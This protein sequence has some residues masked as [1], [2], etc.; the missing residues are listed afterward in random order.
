MLASWRC[1]Q[2]TDDPKVLEAVQEIWHGFYVNELEAFYLANRSVALVEHGLQA[3]R[4]TT[5][6]DAVAAS[7]LAFWH[8]GRL[9]ILIW[10]LEE[11]ATKA[12]AESRETF[13]LR[14]EAML[15]AMSGL[16]RNNPGAFRPILDIQHVELFLVWRAL[17]AF[18]QF[19]NIDTWLGLLG[20]RLMM[21]RLGKTG[22]PFISGANSWEQA[23][24]RAD[25]N[26]ERAFGDT[27]SN[28]L[29]M[30][31]ELSCCLSAARRDPLLR[32]YFCRII[33]AA[34]DEGKQLGKFP[35]ISLMSWAPP[36]GWEARIL[37]GAVVDGIAIPTDFT[38]DFE[39]EGLKLAEQLAS[40]AY[41]ARQSFPLNL[42]SR[43]PCSVFASPIPPEFWRSLILKSE[44]SPTAGAE[45]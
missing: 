1:A 10:A 32:F 20:E 43:V 44:P 37:E 29:L 2:K 41:A 14:R 23:F 22:P 3:E 34:D 25:G 8:L 17:W 31:L 36:L 13:R 16:I 27:S 24:E 6:L 21:R 12:P 7:Y 15:N 9:G 26:T 35:P 4:S 11:L 42:G 33:M 38:P 30:L 28:L 45:S 39:S 5:S 19:Q 18:G 40:S